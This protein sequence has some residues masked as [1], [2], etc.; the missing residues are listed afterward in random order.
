MWWRFF[1]NECECVVGRRALD[2]IRISDT[3]RCWRYEISQ[4]FT[5]Q[6]RAW[7]LKINTK[8]SRFFPELHRLCHMCNLRSDLI[9]SSKFTQTLSN[10]LTNLRLWIHDRM[11]EVEPTTSKQNRES[12]ENQRKIFNFRF[13]FLVIFLFDRR[14][15][16]KKMKE[17]KN[18]DRKVQTT[19]S[20]RVSRF[21]Y[22]QVWGSPRGN[23]WAKIFEEEESWAHTNIFF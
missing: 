21:W 9:I 1:V 12:Y 16:Q 23:I 20:L 4:F 6:A 10:S 14:W 7:I 19:L 22:L 18:D 15:A 5:W 11:R 8:F 17:E 2:L 3:K 13:F